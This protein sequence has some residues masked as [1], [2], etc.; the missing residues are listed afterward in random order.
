MTTSNIAG[1][2]CLY[3]TRDTGAGWIA[4]V[5]PGL[6]QLLGD[7]R[8]SVGLS[9]TEAIWRAADA[10]VRSRAAAGELEPYRGDVD[11]HDAGGI[12]HVTLPLAL[13]PAATYAELKWQP[14]RVWSASHAPA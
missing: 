12:R 7:G 14:V 4:T 5:G 13:L 3:G 2:I 6:D 1:T 9:F 8:P 10:I 11:I